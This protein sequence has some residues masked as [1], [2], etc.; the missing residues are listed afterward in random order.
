M[1]DT[2]FSAAMLK[3]L[4]EDAANRPAS[5]KELWELADEFIELRNEFRDYLDGKGKSGGRKR[6]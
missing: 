5:R 4:G 1:P 6:N 2:N 3:E